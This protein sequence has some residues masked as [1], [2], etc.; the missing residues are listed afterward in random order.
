LKGN[1]LRFCCFLMALMAPAMAG[2]ALAQ[3]DT[4]ENARLTVSGDV[5]L[6][7]KYVWRG[8]STTDGAVVQPSVTLEHPSGLCFNL[9]ANVDATDVNDQ[10]GKIS[11]IDYTLDYTWQGYGSDLSVGAVHYTFPNTGIEST[12]EV[13]LGAGFDAPLCPCARL[14]YDFGQT[15]GFYLSLGGS[16]SLG[17]SAGRLDSI[18]LSASLGLGSS[19][20]NSFYFGEGKTALTDLLLSAGAPIQVN[21]NLTVVPSITYTCILDGSLRD[22]VDEPDNL[23]AGVVASFSL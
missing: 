13:Y 21:N 2:A 11:E 6:F 1:Y 18:D 14:Y 16:H 10:S 12:S 20:Y 23:F 8:I 22:K 5:A 3:E 9:W 19:N 15:D 17:L 4:V 7:G